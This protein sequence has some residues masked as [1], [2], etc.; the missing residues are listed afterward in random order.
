M[1]PV[2]T[3]VVACMPA[4]SVGHDHGTQLGTRN[5]VLD[6][7]ARSHMRMGNFEEKRGGPSDGGLMIVPCVMALYNH[8]SSVQWVYRLTSTFI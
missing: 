1:R 2:V 7:S 8:K 4:L 6:G 3:D 5:R